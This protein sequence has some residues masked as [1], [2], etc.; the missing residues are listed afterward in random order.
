MLPEL[1]FVDSY[2]TD[3]GVYFYA[4]LNKNNYYKTM[5]RLRANAKEISLDYVSQAD[6]KFGKESLVFI[7]SAW[8]EIFPFNDE[9]IEVKYDNQKFN[10]FSLIRQKHEE[11]VKRISIKANFKKENN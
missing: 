10:L 7:Q 4:R 6:K 5:E 8:Q 2:N 9:P 3:N 1:E 11:Y